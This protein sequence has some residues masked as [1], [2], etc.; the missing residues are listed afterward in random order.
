MSGRAARGVLFTSPVSFTSVCQHIHEATPPEATPPCMSVRFMP[1]V[2]FKADLLQHINTL[3]TVSAFSSAVQIHSWC[4]VPTCN[5]VIYCL[6]SD[7]NNCCCEMNHLHLLFPQTG[8]SRRHRSS[9]SQ[10][11]PGTKGTVSPVVVRVSV[12]SQE[13][14]SYDHC[15]VFQ[16]LQGARGPQGPTGP[17]GT[18]VRTF[19]TDLKST[20]PHGS[21]CFC[22]TSPARG[23]TRFK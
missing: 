20:G 3:Y 4:K 7:S 13:A 1:S 12:S 8:F 6:A 18:E 14:S 23:D 11:P 21:D 10:R 5:T 19:N 22:K 17:K 9:R 15:V 16:G 2:I